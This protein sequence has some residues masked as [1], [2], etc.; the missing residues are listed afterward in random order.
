MPREVMEAYMYLAALRAEKTLE[1][2]EAE[3][4]AAKMEAEY[5]SQDMSSAAA[6][7]LTRASDVGLKALKLRAGVS[8]L[9]EMIKALKR[10]QQFHSDEARNLI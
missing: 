1:L 8:G 3:V 10:A 4:E 2:A 6:K 7:T 5:I 9:E